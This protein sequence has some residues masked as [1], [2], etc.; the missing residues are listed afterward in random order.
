MSRPSL[1]GDVRQSLPGDVRQSLPSDARQSSPGDARRSVP[2]IQ[3]SDLRDLATDD[4]VERIWARLEPEVE[5]LRVGSKLVIRT[6]NTEY[7][8]VLIDP[9]GRLGLLSTGPRDEPQEAML[10]CAVSVAPRTIWPSAD[11]VV[12][13]PNLPMRAIE[14]SAWAMMLCP[15]MVAEVC[16]MPSAVVATAIDQTCSATARVKAAIAPTTIPKT[17]RTAG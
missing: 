17:K 4:R 8:F 3:A 11:T 2:R 15:P 14:L 12:S 6:R 16:P 5:S 13:V 1:P 10:A 7:A 9:P